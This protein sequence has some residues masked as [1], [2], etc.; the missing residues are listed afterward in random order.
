MPS[1]VGVQEF[2]CAVVPRSPTTDAEP[3]PRPLMLTFAA[4]PFTDAAPPGPY[5]VPM[6]E[7]KP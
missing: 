4:T 7:P 6:I 5:T 1:H 3:S 2:A